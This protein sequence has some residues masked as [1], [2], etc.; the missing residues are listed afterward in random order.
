[1][2]KI[3]KSCLFTPATHPERF[4]KASEIH[5]SLLLIDLE[6][7]VAPKDKTLARQNAFAYLSQLHLSQTKVGLRINDL[8]TLDGLQD[9]VS[10]LSQEVYLDYLVVP[11]L[12]S[13]ETCFQ[14]DKLL[15]HQK[16]DTRLIGLIETADGLSALPSLVNTTP[17]L[18]GLMLGAADLSAD[19]GCNVASAAIDQARNQI[20]Q[21]CAQSH[22][23]AIDSPY[24]DI[25]NPEALLQETTRVHAFGFHGKAAIHPQQIEIINSVFT[26]TEAEIAYAKQVLIENEKGV[27][28]INGKMIDEAI[29]K[30]ARKILLSVDDEEMK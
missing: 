4:N 19:L 30:K 22:R 10:L 11:K 8:N 17:R 29:A 1:M 3:L 2:D 20:V 23:F 25:H 14:L 7:A 24:F 16:S 15:S 27:G 13:S 28:V 6:D 5:A 12:A 9:L 18:V 26:P 21:V